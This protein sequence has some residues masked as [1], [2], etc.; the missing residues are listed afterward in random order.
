MVF[1]TVVTYRRQPILVSDFGRQA[2]RDAIDKVRIR[3]PF[4]VFA[5]VLLPDHWHSVLQL[6]AGDV[7]YAVRI[8]RIKEE[9]T[10]TWL[11]HKLSEAA[12]TA[13]QRSRGERGVWQPRFWEHT[14]LD[15]EDLRRCVDYIHWNPRKHG[16]DKRVQDYPW[17]SFL[18]F[19][20]SGDYDIDWGGAEPPGISISDDWGE[21]M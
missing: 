2:L 13:S 19:V 1:I 20:A 5:T 14:I 4:K 18:R 15:E 21:P 17:S 8:K 10:R 6:P 3:F 7:K 11:E 12:T 9:F 16:L